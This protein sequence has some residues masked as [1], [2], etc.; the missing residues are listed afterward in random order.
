VV[1][2]SVRS[3]SKVRRVSFLTA[4]AVPAMPKRQRKHRSLALSD[5]CGTYAI[6]WIGDGS[7][8]DSTPIWHGGRDSGWV[9]CP[10]GAG[11]IKPGAGAPGSE[12]KKSEPRRA[13]P[14]A[15]GVSPGAEGG[16]PPRRGFRPGSSGSGPSGLGSLGWFAYPWGWH[17]QALSSPALRACLQKAQDLDSRQIFGKLL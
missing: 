5:T 8:E 15:P 14:G 7:P 16:L 13:A 3:P 2:R 9:E 11:T 4:K 12:E 6:R 10:N 1:G 17:P